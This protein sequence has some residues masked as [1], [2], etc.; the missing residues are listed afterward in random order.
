MVF[1]RLQEI[2][3]WQA[4]RELLLRG[5]RGQRLQQE[6]QQRELGRRL[7]EQ[8]ALQQPQER[9]QG[10]E[11]RLLLFYRKQPKQQQR[12]E[13]P[14]RETCSF[15]NT[16]CSELTK[17]FPEIVWVASCPALAESIRSL[18]ASAMKY[19]RHKWTLKG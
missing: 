5:Q 6:L 3:S 11:Q 2:T 1:F 17:Q 10:Q 18:S 7:R 9:V 8:Q 13:L 4:Q 12:S 16:L 15:V 14:K 19:T